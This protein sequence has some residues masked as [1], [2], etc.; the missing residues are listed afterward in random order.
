MRKLILLALGIGLLE[1]LKRRGTQLGVAP[2]A[3]LIGAA[4]KGLNWLRGP[5]PADKPV[6]PDRSA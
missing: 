5:Q 1:I 4:E 3:L 6:P 2:S